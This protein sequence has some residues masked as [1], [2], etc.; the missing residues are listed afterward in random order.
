M[1]YIYFLTLHCIFE[2]RVWLGC[3]TDKICISRL[4]P[5][6]LDFGAVQCK[7]C[8]MTSYPSNA[9]WAYLCLL[10]WDLFYRKIRLEFS[11]SWAGSSFRFYILDAH[12]NRIKIWISV[13]VWLQC[14]NRNLNLESYPM[15]N[16]GLLTK[17]FEIIKVFGELFKDS[18]L[19]NERRSKAVLCRL[20]K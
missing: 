4:C 19:F 15:I 18:W 14:T 12:W 3:R 13:V 20:C 11:D 16:P 8:T 1:L 7:T 5:V 9:I 2:L 17:Y 6:R 10:I